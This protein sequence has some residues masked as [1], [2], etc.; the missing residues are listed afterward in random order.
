MNSNNLEQS[1]QQAVNEAYAEK[2]ALQIIA[3]NSKTFYGRQIHHQPLDVSGHLG[4]VNYHPSELVITARSGTSLKT[5]QNILEEQG[6][7]L[8]FE[9]P[10]FSDSATLGGTLACGFS[11]PR[12]PF[13]GS[14]R[15]FVLGC[16]ILTG[17]A[18]ILSFGGEVMKNVAGYDV[19]RL[20]VGALGTL[21]VLLEISLKVLPLPEYET[22]LV[23][24]MDVDQAIET[25]TSIQL[26]G[27]LVSGLS[28][29]G[30]YLFVRLS[31]TEKAVKTEAKNLGG[32]ALKT[33]KKFWKKL[34]EQQFDFFQ[35]QHNLWRLS[36]PPATAMIE[37]DGEWLY[38][39]GGALRWLTTDLEAEKIFDLAQQANGHVALFRSTQRVN[40]SFQPLAT[41]LL[42][43]HRNLKDAFDPGNI[44]NPNKIYSDW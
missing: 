11:G 32:E 15:D 18:E 42:Q 35:T 3:G 20:M 28:F 12:R 5:L 22:T 25:M 40:D 7:M 1:L 29:D 39:W 2:T 4:I 14:A 34:R 8:A 16:K 43:R 44:L 36:V 41:G 9:P 10:H 6:Q 38:D 26:K 27:R 31:G 23:F 30:Q 13:T 17:R 37:V 19:S 24:E 21:G 33:A